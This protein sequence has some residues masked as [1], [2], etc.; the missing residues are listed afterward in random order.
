I[1]EKCNRSG[2]GHHLM[3]QLQALRSQRRVEEAYAGHVTAGTVQAGDESLGDW[4]AGSQKDDWDRGCCG[5]WRQYSREVRYD[6]GDLTA[7][8]IGRQLR[9][10]IVSAVCPTVLDP[11]V[12]TFNESALLSP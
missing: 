1:H 9:Q 4:I 10:S 11:H 7:N 5:F 12:L 3:Q 8:E 6:D 2:L